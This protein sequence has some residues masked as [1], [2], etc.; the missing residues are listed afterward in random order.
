M[1]IL[2]LNVLRHHLFPPGWSYVQAFPDSALLH[3]GYI[4]ACF[5]SPLPGPL[6][7]GEGMFC[8]VCGESDVARMQVQRTGIRGRGLP[9]FAALHPGYVTAVNTAP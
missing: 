3:P 1:L 6:P 4:T 5:M 9:D 8:L 7:V 2:G